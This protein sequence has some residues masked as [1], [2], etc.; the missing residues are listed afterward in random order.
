MRD[1]ARV[2]E[3]MPHPSS[4]M[5]PNGIVED[6]ETVTTGKDCLTPWGQSFI[7]GYVNGDLLAGESVP[8]GS[9]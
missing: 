8:T 3:L 1:E 2:L 5:P 6:R 4:L 7:L 9:F